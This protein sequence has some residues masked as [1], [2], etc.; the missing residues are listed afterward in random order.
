MDMMK[1]MMEMMGSLSEDERKKMMEQC[2]AFMEEKGKGEE[3]A[4]TEYKTEGKGCCP[5]KGPF[6]DQFASMMGKCFQEKT[7]GSTDKEKTTGENR[8]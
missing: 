1:K 3:N 8:K 5:D 7:S 6:T 2:F 4:E